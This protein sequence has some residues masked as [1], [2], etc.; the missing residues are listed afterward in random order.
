M[1]YNRCK[2]HRESIDSCKTKVCKLH[3]AICS[4]QYV[5]WFQVTMHN[6]MRMYKVDSFQYLTEYILYISTT[7][8]LHD[9]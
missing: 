8:K 2:S 4:D 5:L 1:T 7:A 9:F 6:T 3:T